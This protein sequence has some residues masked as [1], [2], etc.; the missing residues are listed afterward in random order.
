MTMLDLN[1]AIE[2]IVQELPRPA[3]Q[4]LLRPEWRTVRAALRAPPIGT[5]DRLWTAWVAARRQEVLAPFLVRAWLMAPLAAPDTPY[6]PPAAL[7]TL[8]RDLLALAWG[9]VYRAL[10][11][12]P[13]GIRRAGGR[14]ERGALDALWPAL[15]VPLRLLAAL[16]QVPTAPR[17]RPGAPVA[18]DL[19]ACSPAGRL[20]DHLTGEPYTMLCRALQPWQLTARVQPAPADELPWLAAA[21][22]LVGQEMRQTPAPLWALAAGPRGGVGL[23]TVALLPPAPSVPPLEVSPWSRCQIDP[24]PLQ[25]VVAALRMR[26]A[27]VADWRYRITFSPPGEE[28]PVPPGS[29]TD[30]SP[31]GESVALPLALAISA[32]L[33]EAAPGRYALTGRVAPNGRLRRVSLVPQKLVA[34]IAYNRGRPAGEQVWHVL[35]P[36]ENQDSLAQQAV[37]NTGLRLNETPAGPITLR[38]LDDLLQPR[39]LTDPLHGYLTTLLTTASLGA[40]AGSP[41]AGFELAD[42]VVADL[43]AA[44]GRPAPGAPHGQLLVAPQ[45][46][47]QGR[48]VAGYLAARLAMLRLDWATA[49]EAGTPA[50]RPPAPILVRPTD[51]AH[52]WESAVAAV[53]AQAIGPRAGQFARDAAVATPGEFALILTGNDDLIRETLERRGGLL[54]LVRAAPPPGSPYLILVARHIEQAAAWGAALQAAEDRLTPSPLQWYSPPAT[55]DD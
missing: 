29:I 17:L 33:R 24:T 15:A 1:T 25:P 43:L 21:L 16:E 39:L 30:S 12:F 35:L 34:L 54:P 13:I 32:V 42:A 22:L 31:Q 20:V 26:L 3:R 50:P 14:G 41:P 53:V 5:S 48:A 4:A 10:G 27:E 46:L 23:L 47:D 55:L 11:A 38:T 6:P 40:A 51:L 9:A 36:T 28:P 49:W 18:P 45:G 8:H 52:G 19:V 7:A 2:T 37:T 44:V